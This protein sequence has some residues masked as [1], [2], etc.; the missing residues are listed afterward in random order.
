MKRIQSERE[1]RAIYG[2]PSG[3]AEQKV[4]KEL[5]K[6]SIHFIEQSPFFILSTANK[7]GM[8]DASPRGGEKGFVHVKSSTELLIP[9]AKGNNRLDSL[10]NIVET[11]KCG[12]LFLIPGVDETLRINGKANI[13]TDPELLQLFTSSDKKVKS[14]LH[15]E[16]EELFM[17]CA[18]AF[19]R[20]RLWDSTTQIKREEFPTMGEILKDQLDLS[21]QPESHT[22]M[23]KRYQSDL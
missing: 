9:D 4:L 15:I 5:E 19:M 3:R 20:S 12:L 7:N 10:V 13:S 11:G 8:V 1:L 17:H 21:E 22:D 23:V 14:V 18:K 6:H 16:I 2:S